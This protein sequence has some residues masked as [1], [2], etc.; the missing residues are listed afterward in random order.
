[1]T[2]DQSDFNLSELTG[3]PVDK[4]QGLVAEIQSAYH[5]YKISKGNGKFRVIKAPNDELKE[6]QNRLLHEVFYTV[7]PHDVAHGFVPNRSI[8]TNAKPHV[9]Q[10]MV[11]NFDIT[12]FFPSTRQKMVGA[13]LKRHYGMSGVIAKLVA[14][15]CC[16]HGELPQGAPTSPH[17]ANLA[18]WDADVRLLELSTSHNLNYTRYADDMTFSGAWTPEGLP[19]LVGQIIKDYGYRLAPH[20]IKFYGQHRRQMVTGLVVNEKINIPRKT[21]KRLRA[22]LH[23]METNGPQQALERCAWNEDQLQGFFSLQMMWDRESAKEQMDNLRTLLA[24]L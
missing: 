6:I 23:D 11:A 24:S 22:I 12:D 13:I 14:G 16:L 15:L 20:K 10:R 18:M 7:M 19:K 3:C 2:I 5:I 4:L 9:G 8:L 1:M 21:R 17:L